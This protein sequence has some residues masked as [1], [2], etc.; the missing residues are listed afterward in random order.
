MRLTVRIKPGAKTEAV[1][2][3]LNNEFLVRVKSPAIEGKA[4]KALIKALSGYFNIQKN[5]ISIARGLNS[6]N[7]IV[8]II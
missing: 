1:E 7:K 2:K 8:D 4:N 5:R 3:L 6:K